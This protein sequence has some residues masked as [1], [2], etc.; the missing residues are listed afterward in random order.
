MPFLALATAFLMFEMNG[1]VVEEIVLPVGGEWL[2]AF[3][4]RVEEPLVRDLV[5]ELIPNLREN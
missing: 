5:D 3:V 4:R 1:G 2:V